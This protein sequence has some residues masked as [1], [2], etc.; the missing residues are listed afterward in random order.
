M[1]CKSKKDTISIRSI[2]FGTNLSIYVKITGYLD[3]GSN[4]SNFLEF[5][6]N[7][8]DCWLWTKIVKK[9]PSFSPNFENVDF[10]S[11]LFF[12]SKSPKYWHR[13][14][15]V[16]APILSQNC[17]HSRLSVNFKTKLSILSILSQRCPKC[18]IFV[19]NVEF[20]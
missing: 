15:I 13:V 16:K 11:K 20:A 6:P 19:K 1:L 10:E 4:L 14:K 9:I 18:W 2:D 17:Q 8:R 5:E 7:L 3:F 12:G